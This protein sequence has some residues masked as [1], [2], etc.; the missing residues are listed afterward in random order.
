M[1]HCCVNGRRR[2]NSQL[3][4]PGIHYLHNKI[5]PFY[6]VTEQHDGKETCITQKKNN[7]AKKS[8]R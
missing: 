8:Q 6:N 7:Y 4:A 5:Q 2:G 3:V 1:F